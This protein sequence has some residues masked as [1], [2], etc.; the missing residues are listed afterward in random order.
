MDHEVFPTAGSV[1]Q[2]STVDDTAD[3]SWFIRFMDVANVVPG[4][5]RGW[6]SL[7]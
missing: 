4:Y 1:G 6:S 2:F 5:G 3:A 7:V